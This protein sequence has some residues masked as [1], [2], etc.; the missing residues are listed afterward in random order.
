MFEFLFTNYGVTI[1]V[2]FVVI[3]VLVLGVYLFVRNRKNK[4]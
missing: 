1:G 2:A 4:D 3:V